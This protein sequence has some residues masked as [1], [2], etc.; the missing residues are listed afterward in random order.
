MLGSWETSCDTRGARQDGGH[1]RSQQ[2][3]SIDGEAAQ[4]MDG[5]Y[6]EL[7]AAQNLLTSVLQDLSCKSFLIVAD[8]HEGSGRDPGTDQV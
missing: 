7:G 8:L 1:G 6:G 2:Y 3:S 4:H 5:R